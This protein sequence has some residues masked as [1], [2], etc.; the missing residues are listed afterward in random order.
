MQQSLNIHLEDVTSR[1][2][3][4]VRDYGLNKIQSAD[5]ISS[6]YESRK[7]EVSDEDANA[8]SPT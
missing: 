6:D 5:G 7:G 3:F 8:I 1:A 4:V 2:R